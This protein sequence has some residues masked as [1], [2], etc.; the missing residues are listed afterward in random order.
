[1]SHRFSEEFKTIDEY[2]A[3]KLEKFSRQE[4]NFRTL[5]DMMFSEKDNVLF[6]KSEGYRITEI[7]YG[8]CRDSIERRAFQLDR[9]L[10]DIPKGSLIGIYT[11]Q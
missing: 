8:Q 9:L 7:T 11:I 10:D 4:K 3:A 6:E 1:M 2:V 5:F